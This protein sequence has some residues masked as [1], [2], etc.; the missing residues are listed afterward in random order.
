MRA[1]SA[2]SEVNEANEALDAPE[3]R[4]AIDA[5]KSHACEAYSTRAV[6]VDREAFTAFKMRDASEAPF[7]VQRVLVKIIGT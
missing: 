4:D 3:A 7:R 1:S 5:L 6:T 2:R